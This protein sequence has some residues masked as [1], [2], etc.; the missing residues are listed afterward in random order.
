[1]VTTVKERQGLGESLDR[2]PMSSLHVR[3]WLVAGLG[4]MLDGFDFF[5][6][7][8]ANPLISEDF[9]VSSVEK[10]LVSIADPDARP[11]RKGKLGK[12]TEFGYVAQSAR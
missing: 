8:V 12:P 7:G 2:A 9:G 1:M 4:I 6:I 3:F 10:G 11:I 5:I